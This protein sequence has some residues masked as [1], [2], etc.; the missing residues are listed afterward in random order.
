[1]AKNRHWIQTPDIISV[2]KLIM[3]SKMKCS[4]TQQVSIYTSTVYHGEIVTDTCRNTYCIIVYNDGNSKQPKHS[5]AGVE[6][7]NGYTTR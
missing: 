4:C 7:I 5:P 1:M 6:Q 3:I 2:G